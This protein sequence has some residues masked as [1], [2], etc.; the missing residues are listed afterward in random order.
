M[1]T[2]FLIEPAYFS[3]RELENSLKEATAAIRA[4]SLM[5][6]KEDVVRTLLESGLIGK[7]SSI[8]IITPNN[9]YVKYTR[10]KGLYSKI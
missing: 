2:Y 9:E 4:E 8:S 10:G 7:V 3:G 5:Y 6:Y 1:K